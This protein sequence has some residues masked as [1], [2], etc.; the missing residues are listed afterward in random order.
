MFNGILITT[1]CIFISVYDLILVASQ[2]VPWA[3]NFILLSFK[4]VFI[5]NKIVTATNN[6]V[7]ITINVIFITRNLIVIFQDFILASC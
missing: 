5:T 3:L 6:H 4:S 2:Q 1:D 7:T